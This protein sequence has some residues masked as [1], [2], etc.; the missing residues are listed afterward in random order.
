MKLNLRWVAVSLAAALSLLTMVAV[1]AVNATLDLTVDPEHGIR[2]E[3]VTIQVI[4]TNPDA[5]ALEQVT[6]FAPLPAGI[7]QWDAEVRIS[8]WGWEA[9]PANG[10]ISIGTIAAQSEA[11]VEIQLPLEQA[12]PGTL[13]MTFQLLGIGGVL[14]Q[15]TL[16]FNVLP[17]VDAGPDLIVD[18][19]TAAPITEA[20]ASDGLDGLAA[21]AW[22]DNGAGGVFDNES[23]L[24]PTYTP[25]AQSGLL[26][27]TL[28]VTDHEGAV[29]EDSLRLRVNG[30]PSVALGEDR[31]AT[32]GE[33]ID[34]SGAVATDTDGWIAEY[35][36]SDGGA[37]GSFIP[38][39]NDSTPRYIVPWMPGC[40]DGWITV[41]LAVTDDWGAQSE[42][43]ISVF[44]TNNNAA[45]Q[46]EVLGDIELRSGDEGT[47]VGQAEDT[48]GEIVDAG[49][50]Q[51]EGPSVSLIESGSPGRVIYE[52]PDVLIE[53]QLVFE[54]TA[55]DACGDLA[56]A[57]FHVTVLPTE[58]GGGDG[59]SP[60][61]SS[62]L[63]LRLS[64]HDLRGFPLDG[65]VSPHVGDLIVVRLEVRNLSSVGFS[66][67]QAS[68]AGNEA[69]R[70]MADRLPAWAD[71]S[72]SVE[73][74]VEAGD[75]KPFLQIAA[76]VEAV[77]AQG[78]VHR[79]SDDFSFAPPEDSNAEAS[80]VLEKIASAQ[81]AR[82]GE[83]IACTFTIRNN[84]TMDLEGL[85]LQDE[86][87]GW[88]ALPT[89]SLAAGEIIVVEASSEIRD[90]DLPGP[91]TSLATAAAFTSTGARVDASAETSILL[92]GPEVGG[93]GSTRAT[94][95]AALAAMTWAAQPRAVVLNEIAWAGSVGD[96]GA[97]WIELLNLSG[98][99]IDLSGWSIRWFE[100]R[101]ESA[102]DEIV[103][104]S[105][106]LSGSIDPLPQ[107]A[108]LED[109]KTLKF[110]E[111]SE[112]VWRAFDFAWWGQGKTG[113]EGRGYYLL[114]R[115]HDQVVQNV[116]ADLVYGTDASG[117]LELP[118]NGAAMF[119]INSAG[120]IVDTANAQTGGEGWAA[121]GVDTFATMERVNPFAPDYAGNWQTHAGVLA[122]G[123]CQEG[124]LLRGTA[125]KPNSPSAGDFLSAVRNALPPLPMQEQEIVVIPNLAQ[126]NLASVQIMSL[127]TQGLAG[128]GGAT[129]VPAISTQRNG[130]ELVLA[131]D[132]RGVAPGEYYVCI[133]LSNGDALVLP[134]LVSDS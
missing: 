127:P 72:G 123:L 94:E 46:V 33:T 85:S 63:S 122:F 86:R 36:W 118:D 25:P 81:E 74:W 97:E 67:V 59:G 114:E 42:D 68:L 84:G 101:G 61:N 95:A 47:L 102:T 110:V 112:N 116:V 3:P 4:A 113:T 37:G 38:S 76:I 92:L 82:V 78:T 80:L 51:L 89:Q 90:V 21:I 111:S 13:E 66:S 69:V 103:W 1:G 39:A 120:E 53:T 71:T 52:A 58:S 29:A 62:L 99:S 23:V 75:L 5:T 128:G 87:F 91:L 2:G 16:A 49:W 32:E 31:S 44:V 105:I 26:E 119:L 124:R 17:S 28:V 83:T 20:S 18:L 125:G 104:H 131:L 19:G 129:S 117:S 115:G 6:L 64:V 106:Q 98:A 107:H 11:L 100:K 57:A 30:T 79:V 132:L 96:P 121:G 126:L 35:A 77:D 41:T 70:L 15:E 73:W 27:L 93:G 88:L 108:T 9:F 40:E 109:T 24:A 48:D 45:P 10:L 56:S 133:S 7:D 43:S 8:P 134:L 34:F 130:S 14:S 55:V 54:F 65:L 12:A 50:Q 60:G 22:T